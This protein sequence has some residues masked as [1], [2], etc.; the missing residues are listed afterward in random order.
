MTDHQKLTAEITLLACQIDIP[1][2]TTSAERDDHLLR[3]TEVVSAEL[4]ASKQSVDLVVLPEL[5]SIDY[6]RE[7]FERLDDLAEP[8]E[9]PSFNAWR[10]VAIKHGVYVS[11]SF[12]RAG[13]DATHICSAVVGPQGEFIG[14][15][16]K[17]HLAQY[18][19]SM[20]K[21]YF[22]RGDHLFV[23]EIRGIRLAPIICYDIRIPELSRTLAVDHNVDVILHC[24]A[25]Y[26]DES[27]QTWH[28]FV[29]TRAMENQVYFLSLNRA[30]RT[31]GKS[32]FCQPWHDENTHPLTFAETAEDFR[33]IAL[34]RKTL[35][36]VRQDYTFLKDRLDSYALNT[37]GA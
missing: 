22:N 16:D 15:Y 5:S 36:R 20:E 34:D 9:G 3:S 2:M 12:P 21:E 4:S 23:F 1:P 26:R 25:Y 13:A 32:L 30:G 7:T 31:Y 10:D 33:V 37:K 17:L 18:G 35:C 19:A 24:G 8:L 11:F 28:P 29:I 6:S 27:F 14:S